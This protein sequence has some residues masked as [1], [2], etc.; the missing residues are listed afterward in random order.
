MKHITLLFIYAILMIGV[1]SAIA[2]KGVEGE[3]KISHVSL[4]QQHII[5][6]G[7]GHTSGPAVQ[8]E[9]DNRLHLVW[10]GEQKDVRNLLYLSA[11]LTSNKLPAPKRINPSN[12]QT[13]SLHEPPA[14]ALG[15]N[16]EVY[17]T[18][19]TP[20]PKA[21]GKLFTSL[22]LLSRST[23]G[24]RT[25]LP[26][27]QVNDDSAVTG[28]SFDH[29]TVGPAGAVNI[30][31]LD[32][33]EG[34]KDPATYTAQFHPEKNTITDNLKIDE[35][36]CVCCR[37]HVTT[38]SDGTIYIAWRKIFPGDVRETVI[39]RSTD[40][41]RS[42]SPPVIVGHDRWVYQGCPHRPATIGVDEHGRLYVVWYTEGPD[43]TPGVYFAYSD[44]QG[45]TFTPRRLLNTSKGTFPDHPQLAVN[46]DG[47][48]LVTWEEQ[49]PVRREVV[50]SYSLNR[51]QSFSLPK[52]LNEKKAKSPAVAVNGQGQAVIAWLEQVTFP[53][54]SIVVQ[55][56]SFRYA[57][58]AFVDSE[59]P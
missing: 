27:L 56:V 2:E 43:D 8:L 32:A 23:D 48:L 19:T 42:Y 21:N 44:D 1:S 50:F 7:E 52:K 18:W 55:N 45:N 4:G 6:P 33:R 41:G 39:A 38:A 59:K 47:Q 11:D 22:L 51:G 28:H 53:V 29:L 25:F 40:N 10:Y 58:T 35:N 34:K 31:W 46:Q 13:A 30:S 3:Q 12:Q 14:L 37:T 15:L 57:Q 20:H 24:G 16:K 5:N 49:S 36:T 26:P 9:P 17:V 54:W